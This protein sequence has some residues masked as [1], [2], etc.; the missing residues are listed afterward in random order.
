MKALKIICNCVFFY[1]VAIIFISPFMALALLAQSIVMMEF[2][3]DWVLI[4]GLVVWP[5]FVIGTMLCVGSFFDDQFRTIHRNF[6][7]EN[8]K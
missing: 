5:S 2:V 6:P 3:L 1:G 4:R 8:I 7:W